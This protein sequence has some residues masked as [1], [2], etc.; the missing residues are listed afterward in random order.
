MFIFCKLIYS[1]LAMGTNQSVSTTD[2]TSVVST[3]I[4]NTTGGCMFSD[5]ASNTIDISGNDNVVSGVTQSEKVMMSD[6]CVSSALSNSNLADS[7]ANQIMSGSSNSSSS[8]WSAFGWT[9]NSTKANISNYISQFSINDTANTCSTNLNGN[10]VLAI[11][12]NNNVVEGISQTEV[13]N[14]YGNCVLT[15][16][17]T[18]DMINTITDATNQTATNSANNPISPIIDSIESMF[19]NFADIFIVGL[20][21]IMVFI[22]VKVLVKSSSLAHG[23]NHKDIKHVHFSI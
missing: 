23:G 7:L 22:L 18:N 15:T 8:F 4:Q 14:L 12:G 5:D 10:N 6:T 9:G 13:D 20:V 1:V 21:L 11:V 3:Q 17:G 16:G 2:T 19:K